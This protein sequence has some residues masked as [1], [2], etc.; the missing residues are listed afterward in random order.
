MVINQ[1]NSYALASTGDTQTSKTNSASDQSSDAKVSTG[2]SLGM[3]D[4]MQ[5]LA[6]QFTNQDPMNPVDNTEYIAQLAQF[7]SLQAMQ[8]LTQLSMTQYGASLVGKKVVVASYD[9]NGKYSEVTGVIDSINFASSPYTVII[10][11]KGYN[12]ASVMEVANPSAVTPP[13]TPAEPEVPG[14]GGEST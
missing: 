5:L 6:A 7:S 4:F 10:N 1:I 8:D 3:V 2:S 12:L 11:G 14:T 9:S 13:D